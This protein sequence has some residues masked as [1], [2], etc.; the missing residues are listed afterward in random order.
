M[1]DLIRRLRDSSYGR[2]H[3]LPVSDLDVWHKTCCE[4]ADEIERL[5]AIILEAIIG[6][7]DGDGLADAVRLLVEERAEAQNRR[8]ELR[9]EWN[10]IW[11][12]IR[13]GNIC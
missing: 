12:I 13:A 6:R 4:A 2:R 3:P 11:D 9:E 5:R 8:A 7:R 1:S 10:E